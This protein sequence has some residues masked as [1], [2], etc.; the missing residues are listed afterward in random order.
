[1]KALTAPLTELGEYDEIEKQIKGG[2]GNILLTG[3]ADSQKSNIAYALSEEFRYRLILTFDE[4]HARSLYEDFE[5]YDRNVMLYPAKDLIFYQAD[6]HGNQLSAERI[7]CMRSLIEGRRTTVITTY[8]SILAPLV[9]L[10]AWTDHIITVKKGSRLD[11]EETARRLTE[12]G[13][14]S[15]AQ[16]EEPGQ[17]SIRGD[18]ID[19]FDLTEE[20][21]YR[22]ELWDD[23]V[24][25]VRSFDLDSQRSIEQL[26]SVSIYPASEMVLSEDELTDCIAR[27][28]KECE[29]FS[30]KLRKEFHTEEAHRI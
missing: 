5:F 27:I 20:N 22:I 2:K 28:E 3:C 15:A 16:I 13:Y 12:M 6:V 30:G 19:I 4:V 11:E 18:I 14:E 25:S 8:D 10:E 9:P 24:D 26:E 29:T 17:F 7:R 23:E 1:M 21:P